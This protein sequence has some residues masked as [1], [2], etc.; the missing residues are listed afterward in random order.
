MKVF[1]PREEL[2]SDTR[3]FLRE[4]GFGPIS[5]SSYAEK[6]SCICHP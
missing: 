4:A 6:T 5:C 1:G 3:F 2:V